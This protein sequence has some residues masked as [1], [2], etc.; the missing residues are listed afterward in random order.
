[1]RQTACVEASWRLHHIS[2]NIL[3][4]A[5]NIYWYVANFDKPSLFSG[6]HCESFFGI[7]EIVAGLVEMEG[8]DINQLGFTCNTPLHWAAWNRHEGVVE[9]LLRLDGISPD[10]LAGNG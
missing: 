5:Q 9:I 8:C 7:V 2:T 10:K 1:L 6:L 4:Q 3:L